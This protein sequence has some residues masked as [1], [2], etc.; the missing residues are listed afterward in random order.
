MSDTRE[1][2]C[3]DCGDAR[4]FVQPPCADGHT[5]DGGDCPEWVCA[6]CGTALLADPAPVAVTFAVRRAA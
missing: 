3:P 5:D 4:E 2:P 6:D 1:W